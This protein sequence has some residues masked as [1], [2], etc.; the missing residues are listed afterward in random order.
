MASFRVHVFA[1]ALLASFFN[2]VHCLPPPDIPALFV[3]GDS[4]YDAGNNNYITTTND[5]KANFRPYGETY[6]PVRPTGRFGDGRLIPDYIANFARKPFVQPYL[7][8]RNRPLGRFINGINFASAGAGS[9]DG[10]NAGLV[11]SFKAQ[12]RDFKKVSQQ[13]KQQVGS[14]RSKRLISNAVYMF[15]I[16]SNDYSA[17]ITNSTLLNSYTPNQ[18]VDM[19][20]G[21]M[22]TVFQEIYKEGGRK[23]VI[24]SVGTIG[25]VPSARAVSSGECVEV[26]QTLAKLHNEA[27]QKMLN[28][29]VRNLPGFKYSYFDYFQSSTDTISNPSKY[30]FT[31]VK[32]AC[33]GS[34]PFRGD[35]SCGGKRGMTSFELCPDVQNYLFFDFTHPT[36]KANLLSA[37]QMWETS[38]YVKPNNVK[39]FFQS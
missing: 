30:G 28:N 36:E 31:E 14:V 29:L 37:T 22:S 38:P 15:S 23:F 21:N 9:L 12:L 6:F 10:T 8:I 17:F 33:C 25:C 1:L 19:V 20:V 34:G 26:L 32:V 39:S 35:P 2:S 7:A 16:G 13:L 27:L 4:L 3:L 24:L 5:F 18:Y 11:I